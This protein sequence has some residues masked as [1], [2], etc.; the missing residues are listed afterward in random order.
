MAKNKVKKQEQQHQDDKKDNSKSGD[1]ARKLIAKREAAE[2][3]QAAYDQ[4]TNEQKLARVEQR[5]GTSRRE[6]AKLRG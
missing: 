1:A 6:K 4:L 5:P 2:A 3:R